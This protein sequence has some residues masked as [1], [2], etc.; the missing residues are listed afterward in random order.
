MSEQTAQVMFWTLRQKFVDDSV[1]LEEKSRQVMYYSLAIGH[2][3]GVI[4]CLNVALACPLDAYQQW[5]PLMED[6]DARRKMQGLLTFG[7]IVID[8]S[9]VN[10]LAPDFARLAK[11]AE[12]P[13]RGW[14]RQLLQHLQD[15][16]N[17]PALYLMVRRVD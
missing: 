4:D 10:L 1:E 3:V 5:L 12:E 14:S 13:W 8:A 2:H 16:A 11:T 17:E 6:A 7:E 9:H 15:M